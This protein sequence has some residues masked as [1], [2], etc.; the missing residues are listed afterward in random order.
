MVI[1]YLSAPRMDLVQAFR[2]AQADYERGDGAPDGEGLALDEL[3]RGTMRGFVESQAAGTSMRRGVRPTMAGMDLWW[4][5]ARLGKA[6]DVI[7]RVAFRHDL[8]PAHYDSGG[9]L[10]VSIRPSFRGKGHGLRLLLAAL[11]QAPGKA[12]RA[13]IIVVRDDNPAALAIVQTATR[14]VGG[15][16]I[17]HRSGRRAFRFNI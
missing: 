5:R 14:L 9:Q 7:G 2:E 8:A 6:T 12:L 11:E 16:M 17:W 3:K 1:Y 4:C 15:E 10:W 13:P